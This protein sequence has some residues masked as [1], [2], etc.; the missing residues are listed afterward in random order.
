MY[1]TFPYIA[2]TSGDYGILL[3]VT[4]WSQIEVIR[5][6]YYSVKNYESLSNTW[7]ASVLGHLRYNSFIVC[8]ILGISGELI[9]AFY[10]YINIDGLESKPFTIRMPNKWNFAFDFQMFLLVL[11]PLYAWVFPQL[12]MHM[13]RQRS[14]YYS[15]IRCGKEKKD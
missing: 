2:G 13:W 15:T 6:A 3:C 7:L 8:Y 11:P 10:T 9:C 14:K 4:M 12:Y 1:C 5:F